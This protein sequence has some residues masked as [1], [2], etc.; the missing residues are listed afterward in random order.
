MSGKIAHMSFVWS[1]VPPPLDATEEE[2]C[3]WNSHFVNDRFKR[4]G[5][6]YSLLAMNELVLGRRENGNGQFYLTQKAHRLQQLMIESDVVTKEF[7][8][9][10]FL[11]G[12][13]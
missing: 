12:K 7:P 4:P 1:F 9:A 11:S 5:L 10:G 8:V 3:S 2:M 13:I 6:I